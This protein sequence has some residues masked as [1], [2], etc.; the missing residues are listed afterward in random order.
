MTDLLTPRFL[1]SQPR[2]VL[3]ISVAD[4]AAEI[5]RLTRENA[6]QQEELKQFD[7]WREEWIASRNELERKLGIARLAEEFQ[8]AIWKVTTPGEPEQ[9]I[10]ALKKLGAQEAEANLATAEADTK[11]LDWLEGELRY[12]Q[13]C[14]AQGAIPKNT[15]FRRNTVITRKDIDA[16]LEATK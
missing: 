8:A 4:G 2:A 10:G 15:L 13:E 6:D 5:A 9:C 11:R 1:A 3:A 14:Y 7:I 16:A 12:E